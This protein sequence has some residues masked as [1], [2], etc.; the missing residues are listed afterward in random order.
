LFHYGCL[1][2]VTCFHLL[3][4]SYGCSTSRY[5]C[6]YAA[7]RRY[8]FLPTCH[9]YLPFN[10]LGPHLPTWCSYDTFST[11]TTTTTVTVYV[12]IV[13]IRLVLR[14]WKVSLPHLFKS[15]HLFI[16]LHTDSFDRFHSIC[17]CL[18]DF[19]DTILPPFTYTVY[20]S[21]FDSLHYFRISTL[22]FYHCGLH[23]LHLFYPFRFT[24]LRHYI[25]PQ[26]YHSFL[27]PIPFPFYHSF[28]SI[29]PVKY[30][31]HWNGHTH[32]ASYHGVGD[33]LRVGG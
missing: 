20:I 6:R 5:R 12:L 13:L 11:V 2:T 7:C 31:H 16:D 17:F 24:A 30:R 9:R 32:S 33:L 22:P 18:Q 19:S 29:L 1:T 27:I 10:Q 15:T 3:H 26:D 21:L 4:T 25:P 8:T 23:T 28:I 14:F